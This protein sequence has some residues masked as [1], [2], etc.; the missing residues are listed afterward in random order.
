MPRRPLV[1]RGDV[2]IYMVTATA[3]AVV[4]LAEGNDL[5]TLTSVLGVAAFGLLVWRLVS[6]WPELTVLEHALAMLLA[7]SPLVSA[8]AQTS[9]IRAAGDTLPD[10][11][12]LWLVVAHRCACLV[13]VVWWRRWLGRRTSPLRRDHV[14]A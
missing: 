10:N 3:V 8:L 14:R 6:S 12:W 5:R 2:L 7:L 1:T 9:L 4:L 13:A 11:P